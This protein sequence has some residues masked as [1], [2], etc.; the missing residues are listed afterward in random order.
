[1]ILG[2]SE[3]SRY[4]INNHCSKSC[5][6]FL[7][8]ISTFL[9]ILFSCNKNEDPV[10]PDIG[11]PTIRLAGTISC[12]SGLLSNARVRIQASKVKTVT[13]SLGWFELY[14]TEST[15]SVVLAAWYPGYYIGGGNSF[16]LGDTSISIILKAYHKTDNPE[17]AW[18]G[19]SSAFGDQN[20]CANCHANSGNSNVNLPFD[21]WIGDAHGM[22]AQNHRFLTMYLGTDINGNKSPETSFGYSRDYGKFPLMPKY[23]DTYFGPGYKLDFSGTTGNCAACHTPAAAVDNAY[24]VD[25][26]LLTGV[27]AEGIGCDFCHKISDVKINPSTGLPFDNMPGV[28]SYSFSR[29]PEGHQF[30]A[31]PLDDVAPG[32]DTYSP[33]QKQSAYCASCHTAKFWGVKIYNSFGEWLDSPYSNPETGQSCQDCHM[34]KGLVDHFVRLD[35]GGLY[36]DPNTLASHRMPGAMDEQLLQN[37]V[38]LSAEGRI[39]KNNVVVRVNIINDKT[40]HHV[41]TDSPL[42]HLILLVTA[43]SASG[44]TLNQNGGSVLPDWCGVGDPAEGYLGGLPGKTYAKILE[45]RWT[46]ISPSAAYWNMTRLVSDNRLAA[47]ASDNSEY[48]FSKPLNGPVNIHVQLYFRRAFKRI[49]DWKGWTDADILM[50][51]QSLTIKN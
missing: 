41:P 29:P 42:R 26:S 2:I 37:A 46:G 50:A 9:I 14:A 32:E 28:L 17:Y 3:I 27:E 51:S 31:G 19:A 22:S 38:T 6:N 10:N 39:E 49:A 40:G 47:F 24:G 45:E 36:R 4:F 11:D 7:W 18:I 12:D 30:F 20:N 43:F 21:D 15:D 5:S 16:A 13:D 1:M 44:D 23:D 35:K 34:P 25:P 48:Q 33:I 8:L